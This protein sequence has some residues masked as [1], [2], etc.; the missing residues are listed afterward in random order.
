VAILSSLLPYP[1]HFNS[2]PIKGE[3]LIIADRNLPHIN[4]VL[5]LD[6]DCL[7]DT[8]SITTFQ[9][10]RP[11]LIDLLI[12]ALRTE[13]DSTN[14]QHLLV[15]LFTCVQDLAEHNALQLDNG[16]VTDSKVS[17]STS[18]RGSDASGP[19]ETQNSSK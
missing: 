7:T 17:L 2:L 19:N 14:A 3:L 1:L 9:S 18:G 4:S 5:L 8:A 13:T 16:C 15:S 10:L 11:R 12:N 6:S